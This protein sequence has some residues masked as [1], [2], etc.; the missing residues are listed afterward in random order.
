MNQLWLRQ[1]GVTTRPT[2]LY[3]PLMLPKGT[4]VPFSK[5][6][7]DATEPIRQL[8]EVPPDD[9]RAFCLANRDMLHPVSQGGK[10]TP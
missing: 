9:Y 8:F 1:N 6:L 10:A 5:F 7:N 4:G 2:S 3:F